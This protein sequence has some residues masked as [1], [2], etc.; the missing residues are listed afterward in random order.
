L[1]G[2]V[3][4]DPNMILAAVYSETLL[5]YTKK[6]AAAASWRLAERLQGQRIPVS[7]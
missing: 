1:I 4:E 6:G 5:E 7:L 2:V 3:P